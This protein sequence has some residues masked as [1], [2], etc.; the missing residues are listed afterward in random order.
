[1]FGMQTQEELIGVQAML[2]LSTVEYDYELN[3]YVAILS[4]GQ[5]IVLE[6]KSLR[7]AEQ[8]AVNFFLSDEFQELPWK[9]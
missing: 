8:E 4:D 3:K 7:A 5:R 9:N 6:S 2:E 1:M